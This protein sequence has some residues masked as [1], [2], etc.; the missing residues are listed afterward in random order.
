MYLEFYGLNEKPFNVTP[1]PRF[2]YLSA[3]H[4][5]ALAI[6]MYGIQERKGF[7]VI[8]GEVGSGKTTLLHTFLDRLEPGVRAAY[9]FNT[10]L[11]Q[12]DLLRYIAQDFEVPT[13][14]T[15]AA[16]LLAD[17]N[18]WLIDRLVHG[19]NSVLIIDEAQNLSPELLESVRLLSN[20]ETS[21]EKLLQIVLVGQPELN[22]TLN[23]PSLRQLKQRISLRYHIPPLTRTETLDYIL[24]RLRIAGARG[25]V[26]TPRAMEEVYHASRGIP[27]VINIICDNALLIGYAAGA[28]PVD[29]DAVAEAV[30]DLELGPAADGGAVEPPEVLLRKEPEGEPTPPVGVGRPLRRPTRAGGWGPWVVALSAVAALA[31]GAALV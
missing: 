19:E 14:A 18:A 10:S 1:D 8:T 28:K 30:R 20:L 25:T 9:L 17:L 29:V 27:R 5:E 3:H 12:A 15:T 23:H 22:L 16:D 4:Q 31:A 11:S 7:I 13:Q 24:Q 26:F 21:R 2:L 6:L